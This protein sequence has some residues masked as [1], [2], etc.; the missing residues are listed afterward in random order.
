VTAAPGPDGGDRAGSIPAGD[1]RVT[2]DRL[3]FLGHA[4][5]LIELDG[6]TLITDPL[7]RGR[8]AHLRRHTALPNVALQ[9]VDAV[10]ISHLHQD[11]LDRPSLNQL[12]TDVQ[13]IVPVGAA[14]LLGRWGFRRVEELSA[15]QATSVGGVRVRAVPAVHSGRRVPFGPTAECLGYLIEGRRRVYFAGDTALFSEMAG[16]GP[17]H[18]ALLPVWGWGTNLGAGHLNPRE[19]ALA[20]TLL[21]PALAIPVHWGTFY[22]M[23]LRG[24]MRHLLHT[25]PEDF[26]RHARELAPQVAV[27]ILAP[28]EALCLPTDAGT[29]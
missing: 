16:F 23:G 11:H 29:T 10:L 17:V 26:A 4:T 13:V 24:R 22:P 21:R 15:G 19:A 20:L 27:R 1:R 18:T 7:L 5:V 14:R 28:G 25:P 6:A 9:R 12:G 3:R 2:P 8:V